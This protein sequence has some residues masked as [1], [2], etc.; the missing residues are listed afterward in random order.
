MGELNR[1]LRIVEE[2]RRRLVR[3]ALVLGPIFGFLIA[4][5]L[6]SVTV[7]VFGRGL[8]LPYPYPNL[9]DN[10]TAQ[11][12]RAMVGLL[13]P[14]VQLLNIGVADAVMVQVEIGALLTLIFGMPW[15]VHEVGAF[16][17]PAL[18]TNERQLLRQIGLPATALFAVG[19]VLGLLVFTPLTFVFLFDY[20]SAMGLAP[21]MGVQDFVSFTLLYSLA[22]GLVFE[23]PVFVYAL[24]RAGIV[25]GDVWLQHWRGAVIGALLFGMVVTPDNSGVTM[26]LVASPMIALYFGGAYFASRWERQRTG[27]RPPTPLPAGAG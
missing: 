7:R 27:A 18:R 13:P 24:T 3:I 10:V 9:F 15:I 22:F 20:V 19:T 8:P 25:R 16:L 2:A 23:L 14:Q 5:Q 6:R 4:F 12:F 11:V 26:L 17:V 1:I 21:V